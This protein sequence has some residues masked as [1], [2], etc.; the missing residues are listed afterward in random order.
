METALKLE[1]MSA[2]V[3]NL[4]TETMINSRGDNGSENKQKHHSNKIN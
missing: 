1:T 4:V 2:I 3:L